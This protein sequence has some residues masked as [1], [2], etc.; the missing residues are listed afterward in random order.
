MEHGPWHNWKLVLGSTGFS[1]VDE[2]AA[3]A[4]AAA[5]NFL[6]PLTTEEPQNNQ[7]YFFLS[8]VPPLLY[9]EPWILDNNTVIPM[10]DHTVSENV[11]LFFKKKIKNYTLCVHGFEATTSIHIW[12]QTLAFL[13]VSY[14]AA[15]PPTIPNLEGIW[16][17]GNKNDINYVLPW[18]VM[19]C[20]PYDSN[21][22]WMRKKM[23]R[24]ASALRL[25]AGWLSSIFKLK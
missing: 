15:K 10:A 13:H 3:A 25:T 4:A 12:M 5:V 21:G 9:W 23:T 14:A 1:F 17:S 2:T 16:S 22:F 19:C 20:V 18:L 7:L 11:C 8:I 24:W 6:S